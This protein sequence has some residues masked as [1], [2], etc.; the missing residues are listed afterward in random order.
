MSSFLKKWDETGKW[1]GPTDMRE[2]YRLGREVWDAT[3]LQQ[4]EN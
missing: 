3:H 1:T 4:K 2:I